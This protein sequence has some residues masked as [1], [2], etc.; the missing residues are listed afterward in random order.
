MNQ[1]ALKTLEYDKILLLLEEKADS[2]PGKKKCRELLPSVDLE[3]IEAAQTETADALTRLFRRGNTSFGNN[4]DLGFTIKSLEI[5]SQLSI[6]ELMKV[7]SFLDNAGRV[8]AYG[9]KE[10]EDE[11][12][13][14]L[15]GYFEQLAPL[16]QL[17]NE[18]HRCILS[19]EEVA[20][21]ASPK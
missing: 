15:T 17:A 13:D 20:D 11:A 9:K 16:T 3:E 6:A 8:K 12:E 10:Q 18:I 19:E 5:G 21:D 1:K 14:S 4:Y 2:V 7:A